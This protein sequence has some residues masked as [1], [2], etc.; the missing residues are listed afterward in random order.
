M[1]SRHVTAAVGRWSGVCNDGGHAQSALH[2]N[3]SIQKFAGSWA[4]P[5]E[6]PFRLPGW[7]GVQLGQDARIREEEEHCLRMRTR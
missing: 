1:G 3:C 4:T 5:L 2:P 7:N 6:R